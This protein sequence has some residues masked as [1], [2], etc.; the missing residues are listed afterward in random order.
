VSF[1]DYIVF[2]DESGSAVLDGV[3][4]D[5]PV[6]VLACVLV[7]KDHYAATIV[8]ALQRLKFDFI[9]H[10]QLV[11]HERDIRRQQKAF[12]FLQADAVRRLA[13]IERI[14]AVVE[15]AQIDVIAAVIHK[16]RLIAK[17]ADPWSPY[18]ITLHFCMETLLARLRQLGQ[19]G[20]EVHVLFECRGRRE[21]T[22]LEL[23]FR[24]IAGNQ[25]NW[26]YRASDFSAMKWEPVFVDKKSNSSGLQL[27]DLIARPIG[28]RVL[29]PAQENRAFEIV[30][31]KLAQGGLKIFP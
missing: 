20:R 5:F 2:V 19:I 10:D 6:F 29:R 8:P 26:G 24:R 25:A 1:S 7:Q 11:L 13:F 23:H 9:G 14:N 16:P 3:D 12:A 17:Y 31:S 15:A 28:L 30:R 21:D 27:A 4:P 18:E 22:E